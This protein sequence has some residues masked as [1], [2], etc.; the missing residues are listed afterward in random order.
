MQS[1]QGHLLV[2]SPHT[3][4]ED[5]ARAVILLIQHSDVQAVGVVLDRPSDTPVGN[6]LKGAGKAAGQCDPYAYWGG[7]VPGTVMALHTCQSAADLEVLS[8]V[9]YSVKKKSLQQ[10]L[11]QPEHR[12]KLFDGHAGWGPSQLERQIEAGQWQVTPGREEH[13]FGADGDLWQRV[14]QNPDL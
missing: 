13:V 1:P 5:F 8:G 9:Y 10:L 3:P 4:D 12:V 6:F 2:A 11:A 14:V 7:P